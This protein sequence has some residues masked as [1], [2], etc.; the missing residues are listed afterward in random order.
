MSERVGFEPT[1]V[2]TSEAFKATT[3]DHSDTFPLIL[4]GPANF[5]ESFLCHN[6]TMM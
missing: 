6:K 5:L 1:E 2:E 4:C 3:I